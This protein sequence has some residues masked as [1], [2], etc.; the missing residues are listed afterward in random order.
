VETHEDAIGFLSRPVAVP[1]AGVVMIPDVWGL[2]D[3]YRALARRLAGEGFAVLALDPYRKTGRPAL[4]DVASALAWIRELSDPLVLATVQ[5]AADHLAGDVAV[6]GRKVGVTGFCMGGQYALL[7]AC[8]VRGLSA[9]VAFY[10]MLRYAEGLD[11]ERKPRS[12]LEALADLRCPVLGLYG[13]EDGIIPVADVRELERSL[14]KSGRPGG[15]R[16][17]PKAGHAFMNDTRPEMY[18]PEAAADAWPR[19]VAFFREQLA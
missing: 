13:E 17:Y 16:L 8:G 11:R 10:G 2:S 1:A 19:M 14:A 18:R 15:V 6:A 7:S 4:T 5:E 3:H 12:P 9:C